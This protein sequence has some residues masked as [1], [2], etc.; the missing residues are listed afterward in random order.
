[1][2]L[3]NPLATPVKRSMASVPPLNACLY[4]DIVKLI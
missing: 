3:G 1:M 4:P 2:V